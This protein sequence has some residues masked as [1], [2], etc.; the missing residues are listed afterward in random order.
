MKKILTLINHPSEFEDYIETFLEEGG[1]L[2]TIQPHEL[3]FSTAE[4]EYYFVVLPIDVNFQPLHEVPQ[5]Q[6]DMIDTTR[7][8]FAI[9]AIGLHAT[10]IIQS[11]TESITEKGQP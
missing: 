9:R 1:E 4:E 7:L 10:K 6:Y 8:E 3:F 5:Y 11:L 2:V